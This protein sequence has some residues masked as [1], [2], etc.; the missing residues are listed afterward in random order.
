MHRLLKSPQQLASVLNAVADAITAQDKNGQLIYA[1]DAAARILGFPSAEALTNTPVEEIVSHYEMLTEHGQPF[2]LQDLPGRRALLGLDSPDQLIRFRI[3]QTGE[4]QWAIVKARPVHNQDGGIE[5]VVNIFQNI[6]R[7]KLAEQSLDEQRERLRV[8]L[9]SIGDGVIATDIGGRVTMMN[10]VAERLTGHRQADVLGKPIQDVFYVIHEHTRQPVENPVHTVL[11]CGEAVALANHSLLVARGGAEIPIEDSSAPII[12]RDGTLAGVVLVFHDV[13]ERRRA[14]AD[15]RERE[16]RFRTMADNAPVLIWMAGPDKLCHYFNKPWLDFTGRA[17]EQELGMGWAEGVHPDDHD[18]CLEMYSSS[19]D[20]RQPFM[21]EYRLRNNQGEY[22]WMLDNGIPLYT[23][24]G[25]FEGY[26]GSCMDITERKQHEERTQLL[27]DVTAALAGAVT[28]EQVADIM[29][30]KVIDA[31]G[32]SIAVV[33][34]LTTDSQFLEIVN[35]AGIP[36]A[37]AGRFRRLSLLTS[38]PITDAVRNCQPVWIET[39]EDYS[40]QYPQLYQTLQGFTNSQATVCLPLIVQDRVLGGLGVS[41]L[42]SRRVDEGER[43]FMLALAQQCAQ[44]IER[45]R[46]YAE[47]QNLAAMN[48]RQRLARDLHDAVSQTLFSANVIAESLPRL[49]EQNQPAR[50][51]HLLEQLRLLNRG[52][53]AEMRTLLVELRPEALLNTR[54]ETLLSQLI[55]TA[56]VRKQMD[57][58]LKIN[59]HNRQPLP[60]EVHIA[61]YRIAQE[62]LTNIIKHSGATE[63]TIEF[64]ETRQQAKLLISDNGKGFN[65]RTASNGIGL[66]SMRER[67]DDIQARLRIVSQKGKGTRVSLVW[68]RP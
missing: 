30:G 39:P 46:L 48:E 65:P 34:L 57:I 29:A 35:S 63:A 33:Y 4:E 43:A 52:A 20:A 64:T 2:P 10:P 53:M 19:F 21:M 38:L 12:T 17:M 50:T 45:A 18:R 68:T 56:K 51:L 22:R 58:T 23:P 26:I 44:A 28:V 60:P 41:F 59:L 7:L 37:V 1:N 14:E 49:W 13:T 6:T 5:F 31:L 42:Q 54:L 15:L 66:T 55:D 47:A 27:Q 32:G 11:A 3:R 8:T 40:R 25:R 67:A 9:Y 24:D 16:A 36:P 61:F 62:S